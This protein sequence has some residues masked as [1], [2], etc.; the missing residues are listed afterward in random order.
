M[1]R[2][3]AMS[4]CAEIQD[5]YRSFAA[6]REAV[7]KTNPGKVSVI[8]KERTDNC[9][10]GLFIYDPEENTLRIIPNGRNNADVYI[11]AADIPAFIKALR[12]FFEEGPTA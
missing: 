9:H 12:D 8:Y 5:Q 3:K 6:A 10:E 7:A 4:K 1:R 11:K 2:L